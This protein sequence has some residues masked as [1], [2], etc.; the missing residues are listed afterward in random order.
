MTKKQISK[1]IKS[2][3]V[4]NKYCLRDKKPN[5]NQ[6]T[7]EPNKIKIK[8]SKSLSQNKIKREIKRKKLKFQKFKK[9]SDKIITDDDL[10]CFDDFMILIEKKESNLIDIKM[11]S[12]AKSKNIN[13]I[14]D[15]IQE[16]RKTNNNFI[17]YAKSN[18]VGNN[19]LNK[20]I[21]KKIDDTPTNTPPTFEDKI[22]QFIYKENCLKPEIFW[23]LNNEN[24]DIIKQNK[25]NCLMVVKL[26]NMK[27]IQN[28]DGE[29]NLTLVSKINKKTNTGDNQNEINNKTNIILSDERQEKNL[30]QKLKNIL[31][32]KNN[33][34]FI[35]DLFP[36]S[37]NNIFS[38][39]NESFYGMNEICFMRIIMTKFEED[40]NKKE[41]EKNIFSLP[42]FINEYYMMN[43]NYK[44][45][46]EDSENNNIQVNKHI[47]KFR[48]Y[49][50]NLSYTKDY[51]NDNNI[52]HLI[53]P[54]SQL[55]TL[56]INEQISLF[57]LCNKPISYYLYRQ[58]PG[59]LIIIEPEC[60]HLSFC[61]DRQKTNQIIFGLIWN[62]LK[63]NS[64]QD[65]IILQK[66]FNRF[67]MMNIP[68]IKMFL[69]LLNR[70]GNV[71]NVDIL[72]TINEMWNNFTKN[73]N[74]EKYKNLIINDNF[75]TANLNLNEVLICD[76][77]GNEIFNYFSYEFNNLNQIIY[78]CLNCF[79][80]EYKCDNSFR[81]KNKILFYKY[82][83]EQLITLE[84]KIVKL[85]DEKN[86]LNRYDDLSFI[87]K[88][89]FASSQNVFE[90]DEILF[91]F[92]SDNNTNSSLKLDDIVYY[93]NGPC[94]LEGNQQEDNTLNQELLNIFKDKGNMMNYSEGNYNQKRIENIFDMKLKFNDM[95]YENY[96]EPEKLKNVLFEEK[97][98]NEKKKKVEEK[99][100]PKIKKA[101]N[102]A[103]L[104]L[105]NQF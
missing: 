43:S 44:D 8:I 74:L 82:T 34:S 89:E 56:N 41:S 10:N 73:E 14:E 94:F 36:S 69:N 2:T 67:Q 46:E 104:I 25:K 66:N 60:L 50:L 42:D 80:K 88:D 52:Y 51:N 5:D 22:N 28:L 65:Y 93:I 64:F 84:K 78:I 97:N 27:D 90:N 92:D 21:L 48:K 70:K 26:L 63:I 7:K 49:F 101:N 87:N 55:K 24:I 54:K 23:S 81:L 33:L 59:D 83:K 79:F 1:S 105:L 76:K 57:D 102:V 12:L 15:K 40:S 72:K 100:K 39:L 77:C 75:L 58:E 37:S 95:L 45:E 62:F 30:I 47:L 86:K 98:E 91:N 4:G 29:F 32:Q 16:K 53:I 31:K 61:Y 17:G 99:K 3:A 85:I 13:S 38:Y 19:R 6:E 96:K 11:K 71:L 9:K 68:I 35:E 20:K 103:E 18:S